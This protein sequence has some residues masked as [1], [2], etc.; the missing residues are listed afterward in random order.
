MAGGNLHHQ[1]ANFDWEQYS[2]LLVME[3]FLSLE[4]KVAF[5]LQ[6]KECT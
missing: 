3:G 5:V 2:Q 4:L 1:W 6:E